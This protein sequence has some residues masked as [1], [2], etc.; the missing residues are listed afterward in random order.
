[1]LVGG[2]TRRFKFLINPKRS[3]KNIALCNFCYFGL[4]LPNHA[5]FFCVFWGFDP[6][7][8]VGHLYDSLKGTSLGQ[9]T[10]FEPSTVK[11]GQP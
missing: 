4:K 1:M 2:L 6:Q 5:P 8:M 7:N 10:S 11:I 3:F 9:N